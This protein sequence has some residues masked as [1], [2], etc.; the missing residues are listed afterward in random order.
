MLHGG[1]DTVIKYNAAT[2]DLSV[3]ASGGYKYSDQTDE[4]TYS[5][6]LAVYTVPQLN[7]TLYGAAAT[8]AQVP[9]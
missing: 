7:S 5:Q 8:A 9:P 4:S 2:G 6:W 1:Y 3:V